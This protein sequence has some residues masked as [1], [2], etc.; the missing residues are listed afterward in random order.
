MDPVCMTE[1]TSAGLIISLTDASFSNLLEYVKALTDV[2]K[3]LAERI[4]RKLTINLGHAIWRLHCRLLDGTFHWIEVALIS[5]RL[6]KSDNVTA[7]LS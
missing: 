7:Q 1:R 6:E 2:Q 5:V 4:L 3:S